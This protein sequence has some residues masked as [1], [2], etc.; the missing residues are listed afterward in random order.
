MPLFIHGINFIY[1]YQQSNSSIIIRTIQ[2]IISIVSGGYGVRIESLI[3]YLLT[4]R[5]LLVSVHLFCFY[6]ASYVLR[7][8]N[9]SVQ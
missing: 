1:K 9:L 5:K 2:N 8:F 7:I 4:K 6:L 3:Y